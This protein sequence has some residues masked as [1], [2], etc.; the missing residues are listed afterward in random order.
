[1]VRLNPKYTAVV[2]PLLNDYI[3]K[4]RD[5]RSAV[6]NT[7]VQQITAIAQEDGVN[8]PPFIQKVWL[9]LPHNHLPFTI[10]NAEG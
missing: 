2:L 1:M 9:A 5:E 8:V 6:V 4:K 10:H 3:T 7:A